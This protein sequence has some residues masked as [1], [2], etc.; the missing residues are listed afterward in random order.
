MKKQKVEKR[1]K[2]HKE[3]KNHDGTKNHETLKQ[4][5]NILNHIFF[6]LINRQTDKILFE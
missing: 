2:A 5:L 4:L 6:G 1:K 3:N